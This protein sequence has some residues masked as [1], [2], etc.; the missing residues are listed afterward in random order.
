M[1]GNIPPVIRPTSVT[2]RSIL[3]ISQAIDCDVVGPSEGVLVT[4]MTVMTREIQQ[5]DLFIAL[6]GAHKHGAEFIDDAVSRGAVAVMTDREGA[7]IAGDAAVPLV[8]VESPRAVLGDVANWLYRTDVNPPLFFGVTGTN[9][10]TSTVYLLEGILR[11]MGIVTGLSS[12]AERHI[13]GETV[14]S[15]LTT[16]EAS[17]LHALVARMKEQHVGAV[18][19]EVSAQA[20]THNRVSG[21]TFDVAGFTNLSHDHLD[22][23]ADM[24]EYFLAKLAFFSPEIAKRGV[25]SLD[26]P[27]GIR[28]AQESAIPVRTISSQGYPDA[29]W[30]VE[31]TEESAESVAFTLTSQDGHT[32]ETREPVIGAH[33]AANAGLAIAMLVE[34][35]FN[36]DDIANVLRRDN[37][38]RAYLPG[39]TEKVSGERGPN[40]FVDFGHS[41]DAFEHTLAAVRKFT[42]GRTIMVFGAD[43]D[44]DA[45]KRFDMGRV[46]AEGCDILVITDHHPRFEDPA[47][48]RQQLLVG[49][50]SVADGPEIHESSPPEAA[51]VL[52]VSLAAEGDSI[53]WAGPGHQNYRDIRGERTVYSARDLARSALRDA[54][55]LE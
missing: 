30:Q 55:W 41:P 37:G 13:A 44:R 9:G 38:I 18:A 21:I 22:D 8:I 46:A 29:W 31:V 45:T 49:A 42:T 43:G 33:M 4:G 35:G 27:W 10:K 53:L 36:F 1:S 52:A 23:Y 12:T 34:A 54:G 47:S 19:I 50:R 6:R 24:D 3:E 7:E 16:P 32:L 51:I 28:V 17:E 39:R 14:I 15:R 2:P 11:Q 26:S 5:G 48:I 20:L 25:V 40:V